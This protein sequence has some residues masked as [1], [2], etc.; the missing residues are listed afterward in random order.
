VRLKRVCVAVVL[1]LALMAAGCRHGSARTPVVG[2]ATIVYVTKTGRKYHVE[3]C[4]YL[5]RSKIAITLQDAVN[6][7]YTPCSACDPPLL[8]RAGK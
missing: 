5:D 6:Q 7:G 2:I 3:D 4:Q 1:A 8:D